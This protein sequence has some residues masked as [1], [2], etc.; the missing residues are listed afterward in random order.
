MNSVT[1]VQP[2]VDVATR[3]KGI[4]VLRKNRD[5][6]IVHQRR[7]S[8]IADQELS[9]R[10]LSFHGCVGFALMR[11]FPNAKQVRRNVTTMSVHDRFKN[12]DGPLHM[13]F[14]VGCC[15]DLRCRRLKA[16]T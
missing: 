13:N 2:N 8:L 12:L 16:R 1:G 14:A 5:V 6:V 7:T 10:E 15:C 3:W 11:G 4:A 9:A